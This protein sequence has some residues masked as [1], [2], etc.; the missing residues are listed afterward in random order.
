M[1]ECSFDGTYSI[2]AAELEFVLH[3]LFDLGPFGRLTKT[4]PLDCGMFFRRD[5]TV[6]SSQK[7][8]I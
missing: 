3:D 4:S 7:R 6:P 1:L 5:G 2:L 8:K